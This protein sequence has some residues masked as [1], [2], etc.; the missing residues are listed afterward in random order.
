MQKKVT[1][2]TDGACSGNPGKGG[3]GALLMFGSVKRELSGYS[4]ATTN[5]RMELMAAIQALEALKEPCEVALYS[6]SSYLVNAINKGW[7]KR[8]TSNNWK[9]AAKKPVENIDLWKMILE[10][11]RLHSV[12][13]HKVKGHSDNEFNNRCDYLATQAIKNNR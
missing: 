4:P 7:L 10:L 11:I 1:I 5:N 12:T 9:T 6:D 2:Y 8:W 3:W 13:F